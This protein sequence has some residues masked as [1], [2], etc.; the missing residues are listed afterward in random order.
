[1]YII[2]RARIVSMLFFLFV[3]FELFA[4]DLIFE[5]KYTSQW[6]EVTF[7]C[8]TFRYENIAGVL[9][10]PDEIVIEDYK[11][12]YEYGLSF[13]Y[14][15]YGN[16]ELLLLGDEDILYIYTKDSVSRFFQGDNKGRC[17]NLFWEY[18]DITST[19]C[20]E[21]K[22]LKYEAWNLFEEKISLPLVEGVPGYG[23]GEK[24]TFKM[25]Y[26]AKGIS[27][28]NGFISFKNPELYTKNSR[29]KQFILR[30]LVTG[31]EKIWDIEDKPDPQYIMAE[32]FSNHMVELEIK[33]VYEGS[34]YQDTCLAGISLI[35]PDGCN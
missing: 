8:K 24:L 34:K 1:M 33:E 4:F 26:D 27:I 20:L 5:K 7:N 32:E 3:G 2:Y 10:R 13:L 16:K 21:E 18:G 9:G 22:E 28:L 23:I 35:Y 11:I 17:F 30:D 12:K 25:D 19:S 6:E 31:E 15:S 29:V 14:D